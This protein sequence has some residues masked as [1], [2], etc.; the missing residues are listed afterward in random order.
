MSIDFI[1]IKWLDG[2]LK[3][4]HRYREVG[5]TVS[6]REFVLQKPHVNYH[7]K[8][9]DIVSI[10]PF[11]EVRGKPMRIVRSGANSDEVTSYSAGAK[12][13][14]V[15]VHRAV[16]HNRSGI[17]EMGAMDFVLPIHNELLQAIVRYGELNRIGGEGPDNRPE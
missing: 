14:R 11:D 5:I 1:R 7:V 2:E 16:M 8:L 12:H 9:E 17:F 4:A 13:Y 10:L 6:T 3:I 15:C